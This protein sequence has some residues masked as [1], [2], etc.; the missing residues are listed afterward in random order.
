MTIHMRPYA[1]AADLQ[2]NLELKRACATP[3]N[4]Y[5]APT[6]SELR[7]L[8][9]P[10]PQRPAAEKP[11]WEDEQGRVIGH[12]S[13]RAM[14]QRATML[15]EETDGSL[16]AYVLMGPPSTVLTFQVHPQARGT[17]LEA[18]VLAWA[19][20]E[21]QEQARRRGRSFS[22]WCRCHESETARRA[23][24]EGAGFSPLPARD[25]RLVR[26]LDTP[27]P[28]FHLPA[29]FTLRAGVQGEEMEQYQDL[30]RAV[31]DGISM[32]LD[33]HQSP[34]YA[35]DLDLIAVD[36]A[37]TFAALCL[38]ELHQ[39]A[40]SSGEYSVGEIGVIGTCP[41]HQRQG[42]GRALLLTGMRLLKE[43]GATRVFL[44][45]ELAETPALR[46]FTSLGFQRVSVWQWMTREIAPHR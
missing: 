21:A 40:D 31:F 38:C 41:T 19:I 36:A 18:Q 20:A 8:L 27:L 7:T 4:L 46:L 44:E 22:L 42:L 26:S 6:L 12:L 29:D 13:R 3:E 9:T 37:G 30:Q 10:F 23:L 14:T 33:Y 15:W 43:R 34:A 17:G 16:V 2:R 45:T 11:P 32:G 24:L 5:D 39:V 25:L 1:G 35:P 28:V